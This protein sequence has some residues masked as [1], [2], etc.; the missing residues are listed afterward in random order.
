[1]SNQRLVTPDDFEISQHITVLHN[2]PQRGFADAPTV[3]SDYLKGT[4]LKIVAISLPYLVVEA[5]DPSKGRGTL[6]VDVREH[7]FIRLNDAYVRAVEHKTP[8]IAMQSS[9]D[10]ME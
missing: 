1:M 7:E 6:T 4:V 10:P 5:C 3:E 8:S 9:D 2:Q